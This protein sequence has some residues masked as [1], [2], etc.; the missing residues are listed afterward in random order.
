MR[1]AA[2]LLFL[3]ALLLAAPGCR[4]PRRAAP[5]AGGVRVTSQ[6]LGGLEV[7][8]VSAMRY[9]E[10]GGRA[11]VFLHGFGGRPGEYQAGALRLAT[12]HRLRVFLPAGPLPIEE[13]HAWWRF[14]GEDWPGVAEGDQLVLEP[15]PQLVKV[16]AAMKALL[17]EVRER[18]APES[19]LL[20]GF[21]QGGLVSLDL[22]VAERVPVD[23]VAVL[24]GGL[25]A[26][27]VPGVRAPPD[28]RP[29]I[30]IVHGRTDEV[31]PFA[32][33]ERNK[34]LLVKHGWPVTWR[35]LEVGHAW[36]M[37]VVF[38]ELERLL[39]R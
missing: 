36:R 34:A 25:L 5:R 17:A 32:Q 22:A 38:E 27:S 12:H 31:L 35:P 20:G 23:G 30:A 9:D 24:S 14:D 26:A 33:A 7:T 2:P 4:K 15:V 28:R 3:S 18:F 11:L 16:R 37:P 8:M 13:G 1:F 21:S 39:P 29:P 6:Q 10:R 19:V